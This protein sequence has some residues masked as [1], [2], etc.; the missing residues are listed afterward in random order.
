[1]SFRKIDDEDVETRKAGH[2]WV[3]LKARSGRASV[4]AGD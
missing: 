2:G 4:G 1:V 3:P